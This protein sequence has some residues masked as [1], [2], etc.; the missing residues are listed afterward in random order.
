MQQKNFIFVWMLSILVAILISSCVSTKTSIQQVPSIWDANNLETGQ[1]V[2]IKGFVNTGTQLGEV[3]NHCP[4]GFYLTDDTGILQLR[5]IDE[6]GDVQII[7]DEEYNK[8]LGKKVEV[9]GKFQSSI[10]EALTCNCEDNIIIDS[11]KI[12]QESQTVCTDEAK[13]CPDGSY[14]SRVGPNCEFAPCPDEKSMKE[15]I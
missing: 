11:I 10:C 1:I 6:K 14:V 7:L 13:L 12:I 3:K 15:I 5:S 2:T 9:I 8:Y 4:E